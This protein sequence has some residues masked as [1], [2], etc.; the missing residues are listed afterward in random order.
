MD[1]KIHKINILG[2]YDVVIGKG[3]LKNLNT[4][5]DFSKYSKIFIITDSNL[6]KLWFETIKHSLGIE[7]EKIVVNPGEENKN[8]ETIQEIWK[9]LHSLGADRKSLVINLGGGVIGDTGGFAAST[10]MRGI[11]FLQIP[12]TLLAQVDA[13]IGGK[14]GINFNGVKNLI[15]NFNQPIG[16]ICDIALLKTL[17]DREFIEGFGEVIKHGVIADKEYFNF[18]TSKKPREFSD[19]ELVEI[20]VGSCKIK[21]EIIGSDEKEAGKRKLVNFG[22]TIGHAIE[23]LSLET[24]NPLLHGDAISIGMVAEAEISSRMGML[25]EKELEVLK[26]KVSFIGL[27][28]KVPKFEITDILRFIQSDKKAEKGEVKW[29]L[30]KNIGEA[31]FDQTVEEESIVKVLK[32]LS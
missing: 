6:E 5:F 20:V 8:I 16:V 1:E 24:E 4:L 17:P 9:E 28:T 14:V 22:H 25:S 29:T 3:L 26:E 23:A 31:V 30:L 2:E 21:A 10:Y 15:G 7:V 18:V 12:T 13:S 32:E 11:D 27:P 19:E